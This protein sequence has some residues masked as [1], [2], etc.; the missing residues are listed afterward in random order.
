MRKNYITLGLTIAALFVAMVLVPLCVKKQTNR[1]D[2]YQ[3]VKWDLKVN[4]EIVVDQLHT[5]NMQNLLRKIESDILVLRHCG[6]LYAKA[7]DDSQRAAAIVGF[8]ITR[9]EIDVNIALM[10]VSLGTNLQLYLERTADIERFHDLAVKDAE[11]EAIC[12]PV[13]R[14]LKPILEYS[15]DM[16]VFEHE[17]KKLIKEDP[18]LAV[19]ENEEVRQRLRSEAALRVFERRKKSGLYL[20][21]D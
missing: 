11:V 10:K 8:V 21:N 17:E 6:T 5:E 12:L 9:Q 15:Q 2:D 19:L 4:A 1:L 13:Q 18:S 16:G 7:K 20:L 3:S 14:E